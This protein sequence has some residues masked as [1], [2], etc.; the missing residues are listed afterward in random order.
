MYKQYKRQ[1]R[2]LVLK[3][4]LKNKKYSLKN[5]IVVFSDP[6]GGSTWLSE[7]LLSIPRSQINFEPLQANTGVVPKEYGFGWYPH[8]PE[9]N[10]N[11]KYIIFFT[12][13]LCFKL[14]N[15]WTIK[16]ISI[17]KL[18]FSKYIITKFVLGNQ[19][20]PWFVNHFENKM[21]FKPIYLLRHPV[22]V[23]SS[24]LINFA[25]I[26][27]ENHFKELASDYQFHIPNSIYN[28]R[29][30]ENEGYISSLKTKMEIQVALWCIN[31]MNLI[32]HKHNNKWVMVFYEDLLL[33]PK[34][35]MISLIN[36]IGMKNKIRQVESYDFRSPSK[37]VFSSRFEVNP[38]NQLKK[39]TYTY[40]EKQLQKVQNVLDY[41]KIKVYS[42]FSPYPLRN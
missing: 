11:K 36:D 38:E 17:K 2:N 39:F 6:R 5:S 32:E 13:V 9:D 18:F 19:V 37:T 29:F 4:V 35:H 7:I 31:N 26:N 28:K 15:S 14:F 34:E 8:L 24:Q 25:K 42:A 41:F 23:C 30:K 27:T 1:F 16:N 40:T 21:R 20:L 12:K 3:A 22:A 33:N 10:S